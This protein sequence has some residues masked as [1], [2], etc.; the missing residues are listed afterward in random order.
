MSIARTM[1]FVNRA[2]AAA[3]VHVAA[4]TQ[5]WRRQERALLSTA[6][7]RRPLLDDASAGSRDSDCLPPHPAGSSTSPAS[8][9]VDPRLTG[10]GPRSERWPPG[11]PSYGQ[12]KFEGLEQVHANTRS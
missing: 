11:A 8:R 10:V 7:A 12:R 1:W 5:L 4:A 9:V 2:T 3:D 6:F